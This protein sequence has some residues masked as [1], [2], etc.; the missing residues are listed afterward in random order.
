MPQ[1]NLNDFYSWLNET[2]AELWA[3]LLAWAVY[4]QKYM[5]KH[6]P[7]SV[8]L[9]FKPTVFITIIIID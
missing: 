4:A 5:M 7:L 2:S 8:I 9:N 3:G 6:E 1:F